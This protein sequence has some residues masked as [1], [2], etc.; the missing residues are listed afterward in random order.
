MRRYRI[1]VIIFLVVCAGGILLAFSLRTEDTTPT[2]VVDRGRIETAITVSGVA[3]ASEAARLTFPETGTLTEL[4]AG[5]GDRVERGQ[6]LA[7]IDSADLDADRRT[8]VASLSGALASLPQHARVSSGGAARRHRK[9]KMRVAPSS[10]ATWHLYQL[11][12]RTKIPLRL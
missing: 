2:V 6:L 3:R 11:T 10:V 4:F 9:L 1:Y 8:A 7:K 5:K 12:R